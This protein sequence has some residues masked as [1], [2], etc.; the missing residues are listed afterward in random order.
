MAAGVSEVEDADAF[1]A[2]SKAAA[3]AL[4]TEAAAAVAEAREYVKV[5]DQITSMTFRSTEGVDGGG[6]GT[7][8]VHLLT[9]S[10][11]T[12]SVDAIN[13][14]VGS[15]DVVSEVITSVDVISDATN[16]GSINAR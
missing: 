16:E 2:L 11:V 4:V 10:S 1:K 9:D 3:A 12:G 5:L 6:T 7:G 13:N 14:V 15:A 8:S